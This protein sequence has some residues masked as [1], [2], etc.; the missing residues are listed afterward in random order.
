MAKFLSNYRFYVKL[1]TNK[2]LGYII[3]ELNNL[4]NNFYLLKPNKILNCLSKIKSNK[5]K[6]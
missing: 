5:Y 2:E 3:S 1:N 6:M 4:L